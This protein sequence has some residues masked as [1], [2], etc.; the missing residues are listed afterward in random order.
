[1]KRD[2]GTVT[3]PQAQLYD[4]RLKLAAQGLPHGASQ[5]FESMQKDQGFGTSQFVETA[6]YQHALE[7]ELARTIGNLQQ[8]RG[9]RLHL[10]IPNPSAFASK[11][12]APRASVFTALFSWR[13]PAPD[14]I[15]STEHL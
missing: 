10:A 14:P 8:V 9:A 11:N 5:G 13:T 2:G 1:M 4:A 7:T 12:E 3:V 6:R 15:A